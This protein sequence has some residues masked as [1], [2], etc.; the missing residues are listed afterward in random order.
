[1]T[2]FIGNIITAIK[3][4][5]TG[6]MS[7]G[8]VDR[9]L[10]S[11]AEHRTE[12]LQWRNSVVDLLKLLNLDSSISARETLAGELGFQGQFTGSTADNTTLHRLVMEDVAKHYTK[13][14]TD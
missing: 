13:I 10:S 5:V 12:Q 2:S 8:E 4:L 1:M 3:N 6:P 14:P 9:A 7:R 11:L